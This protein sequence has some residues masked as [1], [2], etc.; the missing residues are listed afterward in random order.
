MKKELIKLFKKELD[1]LE[2]VHGKIV[3]YNVYGRV[4]IKFKD[5]TWYRAGIGK[6]TNVA[7]LDIHDNL[8]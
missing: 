8:T 7:C 3:T 6:S 1:T 2:K 4:S 5:G